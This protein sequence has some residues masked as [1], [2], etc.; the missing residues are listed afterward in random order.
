MEVMRMLMEVMRMLMEVMER[1]FLIR[2][3]EGAAPTSP[4]LPL[5]LI[6][7]ITILAIIMITVGILR[8]CR[9]GAGGWAGQAFAT[10]VPQLGSRG[11]GNLTRGEGGQPG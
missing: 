3:E 7:P 4:F 2:Q 1:R 9:K 11:S 5:L 10:Q 6:T 8:Q